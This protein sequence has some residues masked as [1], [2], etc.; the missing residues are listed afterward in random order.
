MKFVIR[1]ATL[2]CCIALL[3]TT[4]PFGMGV[5]AESAKTKVFLDP[6]DESSYQQVNGHWT[7]TKAYKYNV[8]LPDN[9]DVDLNKIDS[10]GGV[11]GFNGNKPALAAFMT[12]KTMKIF[13]DY[14]GSY[15]RK[16]NLFKN[17]VASE[18]EI[19]YH[20][21]NGFKEFEF[22]GIAG[23]PNGIGNWAGA[24]G[25]EEAPPLEI[26][27]SDNGKDWK[28]MKY[29]DM[30]VMPSGE[31]ST[32]AYF[33]NTS[34]NT[35]K[36]KPKIPTSARYLRL[37]FVNGSD[38]DAATNTWVA[39][40]KN[41]QCV[42]GYLLVNEYTEPQS[43]G[44]GGTSS[45]DK[46]DKPVKP[47]SSKNDGTTGSTND[48]TTA[49][50]PVDGNTSTDNT[51]STGSESSGNTDKPSDTPTGSENVRVE[52]TRETDWMITG[53]IIGADVLVLAAVVVTLVLLYKKKVK[54]LEDL[55]K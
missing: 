8:K 34:R 45:T 3:C 20:F 2:I 16:T 27:Y 5:S 43:G 33:C 47:D 42:L 21:E 40:Y 55:N 29:K 1:V 4:L 37:R 30:R 28:V 46:G 9:Y 13:N 36:S 15:T 41:W 11:F 23:S 39:R 31:A 7:F 44:S 35:S 48:D 38:Y 49:S 25:M 10:N 24:Y 22:M 12:N 32:S 50:D 6:F 51:E 19:I 52:V 14:Y 17:Y 26:S 54:E 18:S 53:I